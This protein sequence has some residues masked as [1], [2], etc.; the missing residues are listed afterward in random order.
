MHATVTA[1]MT[2]VV[3]SRFGADPEEVLGVA[4]VPVPTP[5]EGE[6]L[7]RVRAA[8]VDRGTWHVL[9]GEPY[10][11]RL[12]GF[13]LRR[14]RAANPGR[15]LAGTVAAVGAGVEGFAV[16]DEVFGVG[17]ATFAEYAL[18]R[19]AKLAPRP[20][21][22]S[23]E[24]AAALSISG[25]TALQ[26]VRDRARVRAGERVLVLGASGG[27][28]SLA[29]P[30]AVA[31]GAHVTGTASTAKVDAVRSLG[32]ADVLDHTRED[33]TGTFDVVL[34]TGGNRS[35]GELRRLLTPR[36]RLVIVGGE[37]A[38]RWLGVRRQLRAQALSPFV[39]QSLGTFITS[40][41]AADLRALG[42]LGVRPLLDRRY[43]LE[44]TAAAIRRML[45][46]QATGKVVVTVG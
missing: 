44:G 37:D 7:V 6:V 43:P 22:L 33:V 27:V 11:I 31:A 34:D 36:G 35:L 28:G 18:A 10:A 1:T 19:P 29:V 3:Q 13:G 39:R 32:A 12:A 16:G 24:E 14:P 5:G 20:S 45:D 2:S 17:T 4:E 26:A 38:G 40:E 8:S 15:A 42:D 23:A 9:A 30:I 21:G 46:G 41:N 25:L